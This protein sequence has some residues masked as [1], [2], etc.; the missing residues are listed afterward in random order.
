MTL[1]RLLRLAPVGLAVLVAVNMAMMLLI[2][3]QARATFEQVRA[4]QSQ[5]DMIAGIRTQCE[6]LTF[7]AVAWTLT[8]RTTQARVYEDGRKS[9]FASVDEAAAAMP[10]AKTQL[11]ALK[12]R[13]TALAALLETIQS[14]HTDETKMVTVGRLEREVQPMTAD[15]HKALD[16]LVRAADDESGRLMGDAQRQQRQTLW[17]GALVGVLAVVIGALLVHLL[18]RRIL[19]S[20]GEAVNVASA[21]AEGNLSIAPRVHRSDE[22][23]QM[24]AAMDK[25]RQAW[26]AT[27]GEIH[28]V[29]RYIAEIA[30]EIAQ[31]A[32][33]LN[34][35][36]AHAAT[37]LRDTARSMTELLST[38]EASTASARKASELA[39]AATGSA[40]EGEAAVAEVV[41][42]MDDLSQASS[43][44]S[45]IVSLID[46]IA[47]QTNLLALNAAVE[48][49]RAGEQGRGFA[50]VASEVRALAQRSSQAAGEIRGLIGSSVEGVQA[51]ARN[52]AGAS[53]KIL[54]MGQS[55]AQVSSMIADVSGAASRQNREIDQL[56]NTIGELNTVTQHNARLVGSWTERA[57]HLR[58]ELQR[59]AGLVERFR[60]PGASL[61]AATTV[62]IS[63]RREE[64]ALIRS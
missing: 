13:L 3:R 30:E 1:R 25:A 59:L 55:I 29:T 56:S 11:S 48:A 63:S 6:A 57:E 9:C 17:A 20:V 10:Q 21:L 8:R 32:G 35:R 18:T 62:V 24:L 54:H 60:L 19:T 40:H 42:T 12:E 28:V 7:K 2:D 64:R 44:I 46:S 49:A 52:A 22:I 5:R 26:I 16:D 34:E 51:G 41:R 31:D 37:S 23:G 50:V 53:G 36:S 4:A 47:F 39:G 38:V 43:K 58:Q 45:E 27:I 15:M 61:A 14:E 33:T